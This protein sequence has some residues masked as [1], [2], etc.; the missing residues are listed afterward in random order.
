[1]SL[2]YTCPVGSEIADILIEQCAEQVGQIQKL[3]FERVYSTGTTRNEFVIASAN[4]NVLASW[5]PKMTATDGTKAQISPYIGSPSLAPSDPATVGGG[6]DSLDGVEQIIADNAAQFEGQFY[7]TQ[8]K[9]IESLKLLRNEYLQVYLVNQHN[10]II[11]E[12]DTHDAPTKFRGFIILP[13]TFYVG[14][15]ALGGHVDRDSNPIRFALNANC[16]DKLHV[17][18]PTDFQPLVNLAN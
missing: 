8:Q 2:Q 6:N 12:V 14:S 13:Q 7:Q 16:S 10:Q 15:K 9:S 1:M 18:T 4:P 11:G 5:T 17:V 3:I